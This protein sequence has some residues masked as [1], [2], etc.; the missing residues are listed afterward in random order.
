MRG[1]PS[2]VGRG[3]ANPMSAMT[4]GFKSPSPR[5]Y[6]LVKERTVPFDPFGKNYEIRRMIQIVKRF[7]NSF[8]LFKEIQQEI[9]DW[10]R[11]NFSFITETLC[12]KIVGK[13]LEIQ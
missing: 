4:R 5:L 12:E 7:E 8:S 6:P 2:L 13:E 3:I 11:R 10:V 9:K 1:S